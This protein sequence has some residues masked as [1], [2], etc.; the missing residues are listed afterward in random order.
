MAFRNHEWY[1][2]GHTVISPDLENM[3]HQL[4]L[5]VKRFPCSIASFKR[6]VFERNKGEVGKTAVI[7]QIRD[8][9]AHPR[10]PS[11]R[12]GPDADIFVD[13]L[14]NRAAELQVCI[15]F[16]NGGSPLEIEGG[17]IFG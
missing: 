10:S 3:F 13:A 9:S 11:L 5:T 4:G 2:R 15:D 14:E 12:V 7:F 8:K 17:I 1:L 6:V 16:V